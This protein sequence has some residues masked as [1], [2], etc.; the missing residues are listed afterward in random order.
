MRQ[1]QIASPPG[2]GWMN[3]GDSD[4]I[5]YG[6][7][8]VPDKNSP[9]EFEGFVLKLEKPRAVGGVNLGDVMLRILETG[10]PC[11]FKVRASLLGD[12]P[13]LV[14]PLGGDKEIEIPS[15]YPA[16]ARLKKQEQPSD[17]TDPP[18]TFAEKLD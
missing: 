6:I 8:V 13:D 7:H 17:P 15:R 3:W 16:P 2:T 10:W 9:V 14:F 12:T 11:S 4:W 18:K 1:P 5:I